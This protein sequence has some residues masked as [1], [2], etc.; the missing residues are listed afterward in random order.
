MSFCVGVF[1]QG[2]ALISLSASAPVFVVDVDPFADVDGTPMSQAEMEET[3]GD[4]FF[5]PLIVG[6]IVSAATS[7]AANAAT[8]LI[9]TGKVDLVEV[10]VSAGIG[11]V[12]GGSLGL[13]K[14]GA[15]ALGTATASSIAKGAASGA[16]IGAASDAVK[17]GATS[18]ARGGG[19]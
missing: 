2:P 17:T 14:T 15:Y 11:A 8:Q 12:S 10:A 4:F 1:A 18:L 3:E 9:V 7:A 6:A 5:L 19:R 16:L 13:V